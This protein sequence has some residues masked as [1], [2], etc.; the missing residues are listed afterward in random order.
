MVWFQCVMVVRALAPMGFLSIS[1]KVSAI[2]LGRILGLYLTNFI[3][4]FLLP[5]LL[6][7]SPYFPS[8]FPLFSSYF[9]TLIPNFISL[10]QVS[11][12]RP[13]FLVGSL[14]KLVAKFIAARLR[15]VMDK[16][17]YIN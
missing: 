5:L 8:P 6:T 13:N 7:L 14:Y 17:I 11:D 10:V 15:E 9:V 2:Y 4:F 1:L 16:L 3:N 12:F